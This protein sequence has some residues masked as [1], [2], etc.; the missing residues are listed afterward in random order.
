MLRKD[1]S[2]GYQ[3]FNDNDIDEDLQ[4]PGQYGSTKKD[5]EPE[6]A[7]GSVTQGEEEDGESPPT[8]FSKNCVKNVFTVVLILIYVLLT[9]VAGFLAYQTIRDYLEKMNNPVMSVTYKEVESFSPP[10]IALFPGNAQL[11]SCRHYYREFIPRIVNPGKPQESDCETLEVEYIGPFR[12]ESMKKTLVVR[13]PSDIKNKELIFMQLSVNETHEDFSAISY[14]LFAKYS[15]LI[16]SS[17]RSEFMSDCERNYSMWTFSGGFRTRVKMSLVQTFGNKNEGPEFRQEYSVVKFNDKRPEHERT[18]ELFFAIFE[19][20]DPYIQQIKMIVTA[21]PWNALA[22]LCGVF[23]ALFKAA[24]FARLSI[25][26][27]IRM[28]KRHL[29][30]K[31]RELNQIN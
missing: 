2:R 31:T 5:L 20:R 25:Q 30:N 18:D 21:N 8:K 27:I 23:M 10:G 1:N 14:L 4:P 17:N 19:W 16:N 6:Q 9:T 11:L 29:R 22:I 12:N 7:N 3:E 26:W 28:R 24:N 15:D 13:G